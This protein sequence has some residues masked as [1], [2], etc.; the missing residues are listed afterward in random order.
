MRNDD[1]AP[2]GIGLL[3]SFE[4]FGIFAFGFDI[5]FCFWLDFLICFSTTHT[6][7]LVGSG[8]TQNQQ[9]AANDGNIKKKSQKNIFKKK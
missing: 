1:R 3:N 8:E 4:L 2:S 7:E 5:E 9:S 6:R